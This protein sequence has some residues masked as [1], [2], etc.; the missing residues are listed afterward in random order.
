MSSSKNQKE[1]LTVKKYSHFKRREKKKKK[2]K[3]QKAQKE[4]SSLPAP[5]QCLPM[6]LQIAAARPTLATI[7]G[8]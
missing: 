5:A 7:L 1:A 8:L 3:K 4:S 2:E 6:D